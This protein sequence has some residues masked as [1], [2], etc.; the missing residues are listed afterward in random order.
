MTTLLL[1]AAL[2]GSS[3]AD[4]FPLDVG[5]KWHY[6]ETVANIATVHTDEVLSPVKIGELMATPIASSVNGHVYDTL[7]YRVEG[8]TVFLVAYDPKKPLSLPLPILKVADGRVKWD[9]VG[10]TELADEPANLSMKCESAPKGERDVLGTR[11]ETIELKVEAQVGGSAATGI[12]N[13][14]TALYAK[15]VGMI[16]MRGEGKV[17]NTTTKFER[18]LIKFEVGGRAPR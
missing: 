1:A 6:E 5:T 2:L 15:G 17:G 8:D 10:E 16:E 13:R 11:R 7:Y 9:Y 14:Q 18:K 3:A 4:F 12:K